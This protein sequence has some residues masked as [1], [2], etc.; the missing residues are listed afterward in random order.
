MEY[1]HLLFS[2]IKYKRR[3]EEEEEKNNSIRIAQTERSVHKIG[4]DISTRPVT[5][6]ATRKRKNLIDVFV[7]GV[8][9]SF[10]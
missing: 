3:R 2:K 9:F 7:C 1:A 4:I 10:Y 5:G 8:A 6:I